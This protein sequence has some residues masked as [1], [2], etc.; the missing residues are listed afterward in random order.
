MSIIEQLTRAALSLVLKTPPIVS[1]NDSDVEVHTVVNHRYLLLYLL[2]I[3]SFF[4]FAKRRFSVY[5]HSCQDNMSPRDVKILKE[6]IIGVNYVERL[7]ADEQM[8][9][10]L[11]P[12]P[13]CSRQRNERGRGPVEMKVFDVI[14]IS[15]ADKIILLDADTLFFNYPAEI[16]KWAGSRG[17]RSLYVK[18]K[19]SLYCLPYP[20]INDV[21]GLPKCPP[22]F[23]VGLLC[24]DKKPLVNDMQQIEE[25]MKIIEAKGGDPL[26]L[27]QTLFAMLL[28]N[29]EVLPESYTCVMERKAAD[30]SRIV[31]KHFIGTLRRFS[32]FTYSSEGKRTI[33]EL[34]RSV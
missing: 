19:L 34:N 8:R 11:S 12:Y 9:R 14:L 15:K 3:K 29:K 2:A 18:D 1:D 4:H 13:L 26:I 5:C 22:C 10:Q 30:D 32:D 21:E 24:F 33:D 31:F 28:P 20:E 27:D 17:E 6:H 16:V 7:Y 25:V 23:N